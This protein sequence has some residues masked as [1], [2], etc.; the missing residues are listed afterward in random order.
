MSPSP[1]SLTPREW[2]LSILADLYT[3]RERGRETAHLEMLLTAFIELDP[4]AEEF[5]KRLAQY[6]TDRRPEIAEASASLL[7]AWLRASGSGSQAS[8]EVDGS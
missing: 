6:R 4:T 1:A 2:C 3:R 5:N 7:K 8:S